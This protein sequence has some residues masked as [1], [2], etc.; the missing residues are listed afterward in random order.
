M[1]SALLLCIAGLVLMLTLPGCTDNEKTYRILSN[2]G[3]TQIEFTGFRPFACSRDDSYSTGFR[4]VQP[5][6]LP[7]SG[8]A[9]S[10]LFFRG[11]TLRF[12]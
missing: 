5:N 10:G 8:T 11:T 1:K 9:C 12:D 4:A 3:Y 2:Q 7:V 6:G